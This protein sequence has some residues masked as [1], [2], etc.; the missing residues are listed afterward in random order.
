MDRYHRLKPLPVFIAQIAGVGSS[1]HSSSTRSYSSILPLITS[2]S[3]H[4]LVQ[5]AGSLDTIMLEFYNKTY[6]LGGWNDG[7][8]RFAAEMAGLHQLP[9]AK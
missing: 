9:L 2:L 3:L 4:T 1:F 7:I 5:V 8:L 6:I